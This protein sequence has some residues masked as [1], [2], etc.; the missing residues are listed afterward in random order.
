MDISKVGT[1]IL[2]RLW[3]DLDLSTASDL[4]LHYIDPNGN[5]GTISA[6][7]Y[8]T[9]YAEGTFTD[10]L[11]SVVG[12]WSFV[13]SCT[14]SGAPYISYETYKLKLVSKYG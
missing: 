14:I 12:V 1:T 8:G 10:T 6:D 4:E 2:L 7:L 3:A 5:T 11:A 13:I 9:E